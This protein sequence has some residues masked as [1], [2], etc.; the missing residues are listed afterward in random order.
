M[1]YKSEDVVLLNLLKQAVESEGCKLTEVDFENNILKVDGPDEAVED[2][3][4]A[5]A[6]IID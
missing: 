5:V 6:E 4:R 3:A 2:C 1:K